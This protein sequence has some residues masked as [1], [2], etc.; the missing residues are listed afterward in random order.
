MPESIPDAGRPRGALDLI[1]AAHAAETDR[2]IVGRDAAAR[3][4]E[5]PGVLV[6]DA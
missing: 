2:T 5:L 4:G 6:E 1:M 3:F